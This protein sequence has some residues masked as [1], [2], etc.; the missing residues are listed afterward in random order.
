MTQEL[1][2]KGNE[3]SFKCLVVLAL[4]QRADWGHRQLKLTVNANQFK[5][6]NPPHIHL[7]LCQMVKEGLHLIFECFIYREPLK[8]IFAKFA[9]IGLLQQTITW[10]MVTGK[11][12]IIPALGH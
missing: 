2:R 4:D 12:I 9:S 5:H 8:S 10:Y 1:G 7:L 3:L 11:L 6:T